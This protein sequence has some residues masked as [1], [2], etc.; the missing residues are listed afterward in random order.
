LQHYKNEKEREEGEILDC[1]EEEEEECFQVLAEYGI[2]REVPF[3]PFLV[4]VAGL[5]TSS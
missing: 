4:D 1:P 5:S 3:H 2:A